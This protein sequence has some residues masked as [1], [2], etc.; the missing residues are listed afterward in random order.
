MSTNRIR[1][2]QEIRKI[3]IVFSWKKV[4]IWTYGQGMYNKPIRQLHDKTHLFWS[5]QIDKGMNGLIRASIV[6]SN[7]QIIY[8]PCSFY[9]WPTVHALTKQFMCLIWFGNELL[10]C[11]RF[12]MTLVNIANKSSFTAM[13]LTFSFFQRSSRSQLFIIVTDTDLSANR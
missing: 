12:V 5:D 3:S 7:N 9:K 8:W 6:D 13:L 11:D 1:F 2:H 4:L 10:I